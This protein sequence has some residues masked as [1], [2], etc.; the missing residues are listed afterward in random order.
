MRKKHPTLGQVKVR[1]SRG[2]YFTAKG[3]AEL[4]DHRTGKELQADLEW[5]CQHLAPLGTPGLYSD[6]ISAVGSWFSRVMVSKVQERR[7]LPMAAG[8]Q[9]KP[10][11]TEWGDAEYVT[12]QGAVLQRALRLVTQLL[13]HAAFTKK[14]SMSYHSA[15]RNPVHAGDCGEVPQ[16]VPYKL[17]T[18]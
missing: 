8:K 15:G 9:R 13:G 7:T 3:F 5:D 17:W 6:F 1:L 10:G 4:K 12:E 18:L 14:Q 16:Y 2:I 11:R